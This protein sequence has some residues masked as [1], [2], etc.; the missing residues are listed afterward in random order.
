MKK[1]TLLVLAI[2]AAFIT[3]GCSQANGGSKK[4]VNLRIMCYNTHNCIGMD[5]VTSFERIAN[6]IKAG[7]VEAVALQEL[8]SMSK[9]NP[10]DVLG[11]LAKLTGMH[12]TFCPSIDF[13]GG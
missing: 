4:D 10:A 7:N 6:V 2:A 9:R 8:D 5:G 13:Q 3:V 11:E 1:I 12:P